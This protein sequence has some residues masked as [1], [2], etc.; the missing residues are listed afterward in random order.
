MISPE[1]IQ[2]LSWG[3]E[4]VHLNQH[5]II[6]IPQVIRNK[7][8]IELHKSCSQEMDG[9]QWIG[10]S[11]TDCLWILRAI[12]WR[13]C[14]ILSTCSWLATWKRR[15]QSASRKLE[16]SL[17]CILI[18]ISWRKMVGNLVISL[19]RVR[20]KICLV[21][22]APGILSRSPP[23][24]ATRNIQ[25]RRLRSAEVASFVFGSATNYCMIFS[26]SNNQSPERKLGWILA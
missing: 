26:C 25:M 10:K 14:K 11:L 8:W 4:T 18:S 2:L 7:I 21:T 9:S 12:L 3:H 19:M 20:R 17:K 24:H 22:N 1:N 23:P 16:T 13:G 15:W 6:K 5:K